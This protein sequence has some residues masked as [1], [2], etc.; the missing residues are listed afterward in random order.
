MY[1]VHFYHCILKVV[2]GIS[3]IGLLKNIFFFKS[4]EASSGILTDVRGRTP[5]SVVTGGHRAG[6]GIKMSSFSSACKTIH[7]PP[8]TSSREHPY[9]SAGVILSQGGCLTY[10]QGQMM[11]T[12]L[13]LMGMTEVE[14]THLQHLIQA[15]ME[16]Q[17]PPDSPDVRS[18]PAAVMAKD[19]TA[20]SPV[21]TTQ[22]IDLSTSTEEH[23]LVMPGEKTP[24]S[25][26]EV[27]GFVL[28][29]IRGENSLTDSPTNSSTSSQKRSRSAAR[30]CLEKRFNSMSADTPR[31]QDIQSAVLSNFLTMFQQS[32]EAQ[33]AVIHPQMQKWM[34]TDRANPFEVT[35]PYVGGVYNPVTMCGQVIGHIPHMLEPN[36]QQGLIIPKSFSFNFCPE[37]IVTKPHFTRSSNTTEEQQSVNI[38]NDLAIS[39]ASRKHGSAHSSRPVKAAKAAPDSAGGSGSSSGKT[40]RSCMSLS[41]R[42]EKH[43][44]K[45]RERRKRIRLC[46]D[47]LNMLV[48]FCDSDTDKVTTLQWTTTF[49]RYIKKTY[50]DT[51]KEEFQS[52]FTDN[53]GLFLKSSP[54]S[55]QGP[56]QREM[57][58]SLT[59]PLAVEQ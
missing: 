8:S 21:P 28:A 46:C 35:S 47:E 5:T 27:P 55:G 24:T 22:A 23:C 44:S 17:A 31:Q 18:Y 12:E 43:N 34:K 20:I 45:E 39:A 42:R 3:D 26:G 29:R 11:G 6:F 41:Q 51:F 48:P 10:D 1:L 13:G 56:F 32:A 4:S 7:V 58:E 54:S 25:Y 16:A 38:E 19:A 14:Y 40:A 49:L 33:E 9:D 2:Y 52:A 37:R 15:Q 59:I 30:V 57:D 53:K 36:K 50:G